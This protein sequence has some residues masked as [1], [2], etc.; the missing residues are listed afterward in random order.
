[1]SLNV[2]NEKRPNGRVGRKEEE[3]QR[4]G[5][6]GGNEGEEGEEKAFISR[7]MGV[8]VPATDKGTGWE[9]TWRPSG[10]AVRTRQHPGPTPSRSY[11]MCLLGHTSNMPATHQQHPCIS[12]ALLLRSICLFFPIRVIAPLLNGARDCSGNILPCVVCGLMGVPV[13]PTRW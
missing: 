5:E 7:E 13:S 4:T 9:G 11:D 10:N 8:I 2:S 6:G 3:G 12:P 1:M